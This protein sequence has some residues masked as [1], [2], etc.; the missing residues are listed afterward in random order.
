MDI[1]PQSKINKYI[2]YEAGVYKNIN[3]ITNLENLNVNI[4]CVDNIHIMSCSN[5]YAYMLL[6]I[7][8]CCIV[9][10]RVINKKN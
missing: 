10:Y 7:I 3:E 2:T 4:I 6:F 1:P 8:I 5:Y 9:I